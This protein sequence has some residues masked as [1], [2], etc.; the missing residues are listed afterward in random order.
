MAEDSDTQA[1]NRPTTLLGDWAELPASSS[2]WQPGQRLGP[3]R[4]ERRL[5]KGGMGVVWL[6]EQLEPLRRQVAIKLLPPSQRNPL[7]EAYFEVERQALAQLSHRAIAQIYDAG[8]LPGGEAFFA[9]E[10]V[11]G[12]P[13]DRYLAEHPL[14]LTDLVRLVID[15]C[16]GVQHAHQRGLIHRDLKPAN[17]LVYSSDGVA[18]PKIIDFGI[19]IGAGTRFD[20]GGVVGTPAY[21]APEQRHPDGAGIDARTDVYALGVTLAEALCLAVGIEPAYLPAEST[22]LCQGLLYSLRSPRSDAALPESIRQVLPHLRRVPFELRAIAAQAMAR[23]REQR[24]PSAQAMADDLSQWLEQ[25]P[26]R[27]VGQRPG[28]A[29]RCFLRRHRVASVAALLVLLAMVGGTALAVHGM[30]QAQAARALAEQRRDQAEGLIR[31]MLGELADKLRPIGRLD[32]LDSVSNEA[33]AYLGH[34]ATVASPGAALNRARALRTFGEVLVTRQRFAEAE[35]TLRQAAQLLEPWAGSGARMDPELSFERGTIAFWQGSIAYHQRR[36]EAV[37]PFWQ[38]YL[39]ESRAFARV[40]PDRARAHREVAHALSNLGTLA[41]QTDDYAAALRWFREALD[42][43]RALASEDVDAVLAEANTLSWIANCHEQ[44]GRPR[45]ALGTVEQ[46]LERLHRLAARGVEHS[47][48]DRLEIN[49]R[50]ISA[51]L[52]LQ[53]DR[54]VEARTMLESALLLAQQDVAN[55]PTQPRRQAMLARIAYTLAALPETAAEPARTAHRLAE[56]AR[57]ALAADVLSGRERRNLELRACAAAR[58]IAPAGPD[59]LHGVLEAILAQPD[60]VELS[61]LGLV[62]QL[63]PAL[64]GDGVRAGYVADLQRR[65][66]AIPEA[67]RG[68][69]RYA[70]VRAELMDLMPEAHAERA[71]IRDRIAAL[72]QSNPDQEAP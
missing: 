65:L 68:S 60:E 1:L 55:D 38:R 62:A 46:A 37:G 58:R 21:M 43:R 56:Q 40:S 30:R 17:L 54:A 9:M 22:E 11:P 14:G 15:V 67:R 45:A 31:Y 71:L 4:L 47:D 27:A 25:R 48:R 61:I 7:A 41:Y 13:L 42:I 5:G 20:V 35:G 34:E 29:L 49:I 8:R 59:C 12:V 6:A 23:E 18:W 64:D 3:Y 66:A 53:L 72:R 57:Q 39:D 2:D 33:L 36:F 28:Y 51:D 50:W 52:L 70:L 24:Y 63:L 16:Q 26:V 32:L 10:Y 44:L 69:L 19:A